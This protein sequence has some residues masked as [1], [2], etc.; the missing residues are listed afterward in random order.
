[1]TLARFPKVADAVDLL[2]TEIERYDV[3]AELLAE[4]DPS[5]EI[6]IVLDRARPS[7]RGLMLH[8]L[9]V[10]VAEDVRRVWLRE[11]VVGRA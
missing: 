1:M 4:G 7:R 11:P 2:L 3:A 10:Y 5:A 8:K 9:G 6:C